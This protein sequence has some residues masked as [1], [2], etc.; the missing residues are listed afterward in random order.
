M[1]HAGLPIGMRKVTLVTCQV[2]WWIESIVFGHV[3]L[4]AT[5]TE[6]GDLMEPA[7]RLLAMLGWA[8]PQT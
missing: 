6:G 4:A 2:V 3:A 8:C 1:Q 5:L 7:C